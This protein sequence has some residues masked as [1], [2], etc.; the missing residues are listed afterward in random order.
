MRLLETAWGSAAPEASEEKCLSSKSL[1]N[2]ATRINCRPFPLLSGTNTN[3]PW[4]LYVR[5]LQAAF[6]PFESLEERREN[7]QLLRPARR[8]FL[9]DM[10]K[11]ELA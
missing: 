3:F 1:R 6:V 2:S 5:S 4:D 7:G 11:I 9:I 8:I 10:Q